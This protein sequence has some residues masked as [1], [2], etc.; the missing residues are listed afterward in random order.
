MTEK[1][2]IEQ[3]YDKIIT[4]SFRNCLSVY[5]EWQRT[6]ENINNII[7]ATK[8]LVNRFSLLETLDNGDMNTK[9]L[10]LGVLS[11]HREVIPIVQ[12]KLLDDI[13][14]NYLLMLDTLSRIKYLIIDKLEKICIENEPYWYQLGL[15]N[16]IILSD[17]V[18]VTASDLIMFCNDIYKMIREEYWRQ[19]NIILKYKTS[20]FKDKELFFEQLSAN[21]S[22]SFIDFSYIEYILQ[23]SHNIK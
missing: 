13:D 1:H 23:I 10:S 15:S 20:S 4:K 12:Q 5:R 14:N 8:G 16:Q 9:A 21:S 2:Q 22:N 19:Q 6:Q 3:N 7:S 18:K 17:M 11:D